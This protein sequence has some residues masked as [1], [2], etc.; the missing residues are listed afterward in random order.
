[1]GRPGIPGNRNIHASDGKYCKESKMRIAPI[2]TSAITGPVATC[3]FHMEMNGAAV[4]SVWVPVAWLARSVYTQA[5][6]KMFL[7][8]PRQRLQQAT[9]PDCFLYP[10]SFLQ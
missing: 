10:S 7:K 8:E 3:L 9:G 5:G 1:M 6:S 4:S 2:V